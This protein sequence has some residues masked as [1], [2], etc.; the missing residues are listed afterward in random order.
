LTAITEQPVFEGNTGSQAGDCAAL[1]ILNESGKKYA[2]SP[3][4]TGAS[5]YQYNSVLQRLS[6]CFNSS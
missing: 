1:G 2:S 6:A 3:M 5:S 4:N